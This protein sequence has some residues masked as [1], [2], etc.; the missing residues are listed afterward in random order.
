MF[1]YSLLLFSLLFTSIIV[2]SLDASQPKVLQFLP[3]MSSKPSIFLVATITDKSL[4][5]VDNEF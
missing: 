4:V 5:L 2:L 1:S 3:S